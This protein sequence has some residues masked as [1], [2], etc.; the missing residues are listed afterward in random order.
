MKNVELIFVGR[1]DFQASTPLRETSK[2]SN[3]KEGIDDSKSSGLW[4]CLGGGGAA[5]QASRFEEEPLCP[6]RS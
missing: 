5:R 3:I 6:S 2:E 1:G 4:P